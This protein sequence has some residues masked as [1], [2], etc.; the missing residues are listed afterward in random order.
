MSIATASDVE[1]APA[2]VRPLAAPLMLAG[3]CAALSDWLFYGWEV[4][5]SLALFLAVL[6]LAAVAGSRARAPRRF[7]SRWPSY[8]S[9][10]CWP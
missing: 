4:G 8:S 5:F 2:P 7:R 6:G 10:A 3:G 9:Q 1:I